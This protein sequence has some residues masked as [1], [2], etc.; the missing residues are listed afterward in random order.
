MTHRY[1]FANKTV[2]VTADLSA[3]NLTPLHTYHWLQRGQPLNAKAEAMGRP[4]EKRKY[5]ADYMKRDRNL[6]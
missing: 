4:K 5:L 1:T 3:E 6:P 2:L